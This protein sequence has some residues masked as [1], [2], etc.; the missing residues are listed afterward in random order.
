MNWWSTIVRP[1]YLVLKM[2]NYVIWFLKR[3]SSRL[4]MTSYRRNLV[5]WTLGVGML[6]QSLIGQTNIGGVVRLAIEKDS[7]RLLTSLPI[8]RNVRD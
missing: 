6:S 7:S 2:S 4:S 5:N 8:I 3:H 1:V